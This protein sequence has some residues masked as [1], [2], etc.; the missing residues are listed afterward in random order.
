MPPPVGLPNGTT[1]RLPHQ[2]LLKFPQI[3]LAARQA[4]VF[5]ALQNKALLSIGQFCDDG[6]RILFD[7]DRVN[8]FKGDTSILGTRD[9]T[10]GLYYISIPTP[11]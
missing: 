2:A 4:H 3:S 11:T 6:F 10:N 1:I 5:P 7:K 8:V 9:P